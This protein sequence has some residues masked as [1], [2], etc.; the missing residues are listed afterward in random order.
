MS[1]KMGSIMISI[2]LIAAIIVISILFITTPK[3]YAAQSD[4]LIITDK[5][6]E[7]SEIKTYTNIS[8]F[9]NKRKRY[10]SAKSPEIEIL[11]TMGLNEAEFGENPEILNTAE[12]VTVQEVVMVAN[13]NGD[14]AYK[15]V[16]NVTE[17]EWADI[18]NNKGNTGYMSGKIVVI[19]DSSYN[20]GKKS[21]NKD[22]FY[23]TFY[24]YGFKVT[25]SMKWLKTPLYRMK[26]VFAFHAYNGGVHID[27]A[28]S[29]T[30]S[31]TRDMMMNFNTGN[32]TFQTSQLSMQILPA[33]DSFWPY[34]TVDLPDNASTPTTSLSYSN[35][36]FSVTT[37]M[38]AENDFET[39]MGYAHKQ[40]VVATI[41]V[42]LNGNIAFQCGTD[43]R[44]YNTPSVFVDVITDPMLEA[45]K[46]KE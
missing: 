2:I 38:Y 45:I 20:Q 8:N 3:V 7:Q 28:D 42:N 5:S 39:H 27:E 31:Y 44:S 16:Y 40:L 1:K 18:M 26:D 11:E 43:F 4:D 15:P 34:Y 10:R 37:L 14:M 30:M 19:Q 46:N 25:Y 6:T 41:N 17:A 22:G 21:A 12:A 36:D 9:I 29:L 23:E 33:Y 32:P 35:F 24:A 13:E